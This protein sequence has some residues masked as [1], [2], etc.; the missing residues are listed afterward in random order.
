MRYTLRLLTLDQLGRAATLICALEL[1]RQKDVDEARRRGRSR[2]ACGSG[3]PRRRTAWAARATTTATRPAPRRSPSRTTTSKP[4]ADPAGGLPVVRHEVHAELVPAC[5]PNPD[6]PDRPARRLRRTA[7]ARSRGDNPLPIVAVDEPIYRRLPCFLIATVDK[8]AAMP[9]TGAGRR[10]SSA[11]V[12]RHDQHGFYG[13]CEPERRASRCR[14]AAAAA[15][16]DHP[17]RAAPDLRPAG[18][19]GRAVRDGAR[20]AVHAATVDGKT[21]PA[22]DHRLDGHGAPRREPDPGALQPPARWTSSRRRDPTAATRSSPR[23]TPP[24]RATP[25]ST[26]ASPP[27][28]AASKV[29]LLRTYL[30]LLA[31]AQKAYVA[32]RRQEEPE[33]PRR[34]VHDAARLLQQP[35]RAGRQPAHRRGRGRHRARRLRQPQAR[36]REPTGSFANRKIAYDVVELTSR[37]QH[38]QGGRG[39][40]AAGTAVPRRRTASTWPWPPT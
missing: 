25:G 2:S 38:R 4:I 24:T 27:R 12:D 26:S 6:E 23:R 8:F 14:A 40:A 31:A 39:Q 18:H 5:M 11:G 20:R 35:A 19:D 34:P 17:G 9:W 13:P 29:I 10:A 7:T 15:G 16:P 3:R 30:A 37:V 28:G 33:Q 1:E 22:E 36:G 21:R 32:E